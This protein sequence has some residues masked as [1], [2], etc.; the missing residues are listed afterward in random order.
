MRSIQVAIIPIKEGENNA[1]AYSM[2][3]NSPNCHAFERIRERRPILSRMSQA[4]GI[5]SCV[6]RSIPGRVKLNAGVRTV[7]NYSLF[8]DICRVRACPNGVE[9]GTNRILKSG[10]GIHNY[11]LLEAVEKPGL[12]RNNRPRCS[13]HL[14]HPRRWSRRKL[15]DHHLLARPHSKDEWNYC[16][17]RWSSSPPTLTSRRISDPV[18]P[19]QDLYDRTKIFQCLFLF[20]D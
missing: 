11:F 1:S 13:Q 14:D 7:N 6:G 17:G 4:G 3:T 19:R 5:K 9:A 16:R 10:R 12:T 8:R 2:M 15:D 18:L 20:S